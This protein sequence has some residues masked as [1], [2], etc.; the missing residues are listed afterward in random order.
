MNVTDQTQ[1]KSKNN[2]NSKP[3]LYEQTR[4]KQDLDRAKKTKNNSQETQDVSK[5]SV[6]KCQI[7]IYK[8][9]KIF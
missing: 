4:T 7:F 9:L 3:R 6:V 1:V 5:F 2:L 8:F